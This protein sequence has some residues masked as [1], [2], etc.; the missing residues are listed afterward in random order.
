V[1]LG[2]LEIKMSFSFTLPDH[3]PVTPHG[4]D[5]PIQIDPSGLD[6]ELE[7]YMWDLLKRVRERVSK[8]PKPS[9]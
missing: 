8:G 2:T 4:E 3:E 7:Q 6:E 9:L 1:K 5:P